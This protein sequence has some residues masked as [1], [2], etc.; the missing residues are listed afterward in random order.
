MI[1]RPVTARPESKELTMPESREE[2]RPD[3]GELTPSP[4]G[5]GKDVMYPASHPDSG[6]KIQPG[7]GG[8]DDRDPAKEMPR[9]P[10][11][12]ETQDD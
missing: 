2:P 3:E 12:P 7:I 4:D 6:P 8:Y 1:V 9:I 5:P 11:A 10:S